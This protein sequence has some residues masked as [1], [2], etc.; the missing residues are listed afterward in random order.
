[1]KK[2]CGL[3]LLILSHISNAQTFDAEWINHYNEDRYE[4]H[5]NVNGIYAESAS[6]N[7]DSSGNLL[8]IAHGY[9]I[10]QYMDVPVTIPRVVII[11]SDSNG[12]VLWQKT[13][14]DTQQLNLFQL[15]HISSV[16]IDSDN[17]IYLE[18]GYGQE[19]NYDSNTLPSI[20]NG[21][22]GFSLK[23]DENGNF[24]SASNHGLYVKKIV[25]SNNRIY[26]IGQFASNTNYGSQSFSYSGYGSYDVLIWQADLNGNLLWTTRCDSNVHVNDLSVYNDHLYITGTYGSDS[27]FDNGYYISSGVGGMFIADMDTSG[28]F[29]WITQNDAEPYNIKRIDTTLIITGSCTSGTTFGSFQ[30]NSI[31]TM[32][33]PTFVAGMDTVGNYQWLHHSVCEDNYKVSSIE[34]NDSSFIIL[35][36][37][38]ESTLD[39]SGTPA[40]LKNALVEIDQDGSVLNYN[41]CLP[42]ST[43]DIFMNQIHYN[44]G[45]YYIGGRFQEKIWLGNQ[46]LDG[47][48]QEIMAYYAKINFPGSGTVSFDENIQ[49]EFILYPNP[50][51]GRFYISESIDNIN[52]YNSLGQRVDFELIGNEIK[53]SNPS[54]GIYILNGMI[55][56]TPIRRK[57][58][59]Q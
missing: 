48:F 40:S 10:F 9:H 58:T 16:T 43:Y 34:H 59:I 17:N 35:L 1:M 25:Y 57:I 42:G 29:N 11:K 53:I 32:N 27:N 13:F 44:Q 15:E 18:G 12:N 24:V 6:F 26:G 56:N 36:R 37:T 2:Y 51:N 22:S 21:Q 7:S 38:T 47:G 39:P 52:I 30:L 20:S 54:S 4:S 14:V 23:I 28:Q 41:Y 19:F 31:S 50:N 49:E 46:Y 55:D 45:A 3:L 5:P 8:I 33:D